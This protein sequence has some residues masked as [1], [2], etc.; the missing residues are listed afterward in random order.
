MPVKDWLREERFYKIVRKTFESDDAAKFFDRDALLRMIDDNYAKKNDDR[1][2][3][4]TVY[5]FLTW[6]DVYFNHDGLKP[7]PMQLA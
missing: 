4:W 3:I 1:R 2:K 5:T 7:E 6:Y